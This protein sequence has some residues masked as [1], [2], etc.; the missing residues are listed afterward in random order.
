MKYEDLL[1][2]SSQVRVSYLVAVLKAVCVEAKESPKPLATVINA[3]LAVFSLTATEH[4][5]LKQEALE[6]LQ[7]E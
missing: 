1:H 3:T 4:D 6:R 2:L 5:A 7:D